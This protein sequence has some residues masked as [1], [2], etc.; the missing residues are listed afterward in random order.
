MQSQQLVL[1]DHQKIQLAAYHLWLDR[2][3]PCGTPEVDWF[4]AEAQLREHQAAFESAP[5]LAAARSVG[6]ALGVVAGVVAS[7]TE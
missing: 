5:L 2:G 1:S 6:S 3:C 4:Q 7:I